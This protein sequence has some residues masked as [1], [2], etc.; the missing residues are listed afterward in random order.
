MSFKARALTA[1][2]VVEE[3]LRSISRWMYENPE[4]AYQEFESSRRLS[5]FLGDNGFDV[6]YPA[7]GLDTAFEA[8]AG[9]SGPRVVICS[10]YDALPDV[11]HACGHNIIAASSLGA[12]VALA[13]MVDEDRK[14]VV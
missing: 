1:Y 7:Y 4:T 6:T 12:G 10:E 14:S 9:N 8:N 2:E 13:G 11:G 3:E 5:E